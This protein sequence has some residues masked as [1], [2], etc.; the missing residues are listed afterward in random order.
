MKAYPVIQKEF[1]PD[2]LVS[3]LN[4]LGIH[5]VAGGEKVRKLA[6]AMSPS[7]LLAALARQ[8]DARLRLAII[9]V[10]LYRPEFANAVPEAITRL[11]EPA[12]STL[13]LFY[14]AAMLLQQKYADRLQS[15]LGAR[16]PLPDFFSRQLGIAT[17]GD[18]QFRLKQL[19]ER[20]RVWSG[21]DINW[22][23]TY[24][25]AVERVIKRL[26]RE[27]QWARLPALKS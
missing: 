9:A 12:Q 22:L 10:L 24:E 16:E 20:H 13:E 18:A 14:T 3:T 17:S 27:S 7:E 15:L 1:D 11:A 25:H 21:L 8:S 2:E 4:S 6:Y 5:F 26:E 23:G 19:A